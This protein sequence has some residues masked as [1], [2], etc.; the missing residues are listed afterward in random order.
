[1]LMKKIKLFLT[2]L[3]AFCTVAVASAQNVA[4]SG[5]VTDAAT[6]EPVPGAAVQLKGSATSY[7]LTDALGNYSIAVP[8]DGTLEVSCLGYVLQEVAVAGQ[9]VVNIALV[10]DTE[11]LDD[12]IVVAFG[13]ATKESF[14][15]SA[16]V[17]GSETIARSQSSSVTGALAGSVAGVQLTSSNGA[18]GSSSTIRVRGFSS[19]NAGNDPLVIVDGAPYGGDIANIPQQDVES[20]TVL[21]DAASNA[22]YGARGAN[23]VIIIT[24]KRAKAGEAVV[25]FDGKYGVNTRAVKRYNTIQDP[26]HYLEMHG[27]SRANYLKDTYS[28][29]DAQAWAGVNA[30]IEADQ[31]DGGLGYGIFDVPAGQNLFGS[32][33]KIN[34][35]ATLGK[36]YTVG[37]QDYLV[38]PDNWEDYAYQKGA[39]SEYNLNVSASNSR[40]SFYASVSY[41]DNQGITYGSDYKRFSGRLRADYQAKKWLKIGGNISFA[42]YDM[43]FLS[44]N[45]TATS[46]GNVWAFT[47]RI[48]PI[49]PLYVRDGDGKIMIDS[50]GF[51]MMDYGN[52]MNAGLGR[53]FLSDA[54]A[55][56]DNILNTNNNEGFQ[57]N[58]SGFADI[59]ITKDL[60]LTVNGT[61]LNDEYRTTY[62]YNP[63]YGQFTSEKGMVEKGHSRYRNFNLQQ[64]LSYSHQFGA[65]GVDVMVGHEYYNAAS[66]DLYATK[67]NMFNQVNKELNGA[68]LD[69]QSSGSSISRYNNEGIFS[70][71]QYNFG[72]K[73]FVSGSFRR[74][75][76]SRFAPEYRWGNFWSA[77]AAWIASKEDWFDLSFVDELKLKASIG[78]QGNDNI[79]NYR[80]TDTYDIIN[81]DGAVATQFSAKGKRDITWETNT[82]INAG[83]EFGL[84]NR[85]S[86]SVEYFNRLTTDMLFAFYVAPSMG[87]SY[88]Y[89]NIGNMSNKGA[90]LEL[91]VNIIN[92]KNI[93]WD[94]FGNL[95][96]LNN[97][98]TM[99]ADDKKETRAYDLDLNV[100]EGYVSSSNYIA[101]DLPM[102][103]WYMREYAGVDPETGKS[104]WWRLVPK[105]EIDGDGNEVA[106]K[107]ANDNV[108]Y[109]GVEKTDDYS[110]ASYFVTN[111]SGIAPIY[112]GF[113]TSFEA[114]GFDFSVRFS[115]QIGGQTY[116]SGYAA[117]M[118]SPTG[119][120]SGNALHYDL[121]NSWTAEKPS[122]TIPR[123]QWGDTYSAGTSTRFL[124]KASYLN[125]E[126]IN[127]GYTLPE[128]LVKKAKISSVRVYCAME[129]LGYWSARQGL[130]P[131]QSYGATGDAYYSP[132][133]TISG[134]VTIKF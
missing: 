37:G 33:G 54:N 15:G 90:E 56:M 101:E 74:D 97:R 13:T 80:Y 52:G 78:S 17:V 42:Q 79:G 58:A 1:M 96:F 82:N 30:T 91:N 64:L 104:L 76:S 133:K 105:T 119:S 118:A 67:S 89:D 109:E 98:I 108:V 45:G 93:K 3:A 25:T 19:L 68:V 62:V 6:G 61:I 46:T 60:T 28:Y 116:D 36:H 10:S 113:G 117:A 11:M 100:Y 34:P 85:V 87:Y 18:P 122:T 75:A 77:G 73:I 63:Y 59:N 88:Y 47:S 99:L 111:K 21:K 114:Y 43:N 39:R 27:L 134:G 23:G 107:D 35:A 92:N 128:S 86:G 9:K 129:N 115:Y 127:V 132:M 38:R 49:Y 22:L 65:H 53:P 57:A 32:N 83:V 125:V 131:R 5:T 106:V 121:L 126:N 7:A 103:T 120:N 14:T 26:T 130:D 81:S 12:V 72:E 51:K 40:S 16:A 94:V 55:L 66:Y 110:K 84:F 102:Y 50:D 48:A 4:V 2:A 8:A 71:A 20:M 31:A 44:N 124:T 69:K 29:S 41:L 123:F 24:T 95:T 112:G 70:R